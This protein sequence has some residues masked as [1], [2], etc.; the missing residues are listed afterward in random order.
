MGDAGLLSEGL[1]LEFDIPEGHDPI[2]RIAIQPGWPMQEEIGSVTLVREDEDD[3]DPT[4]PD[5]FE[6]TIYLTGR[7]VAY[8]VNPYL[9]GIAQEQVE[10]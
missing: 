4:D 7:P 9:P 2:V 6:P 8:D 10:W 5:P 3:V 1:E